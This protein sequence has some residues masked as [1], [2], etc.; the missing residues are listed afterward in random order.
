MRVSKYVKVD[1]N[2]LIEYIYDDG[3]LIGETY[4]VGVNIKN[5]NYSY[6][7]GDSSTTLNTSL[8]TLFPIDLVNNT[9][10]KYDTSIY[11]FLQ[12]KDFAGGFPI[13]HDFIKIHLPINYTFGE[14]L[15][16]YL[17]AYAFDSTLKKTY[18]LCNFYY[19]ITNLDQTTGS[20]KDLLT[21]VNPPIFFQE[22]LWGKQV[23]IMIPSL[24][25]VSHQKIN[26]VVK[27]NSINYNLT[28]GVGFDSNSPIFI[29][30]QFISNK[31]TVNS[32]TTYTLSGKNT[33]TMPQSPEF[34]K[35]GVRVEESVNGDFFEIYGVY[36]DNIGDFNDFINRSVYSGNRYYVEYK[37]TIY[38]QNIRG[39]STRIVMTDDFL[40]KVE[41][42]PIIKYSTTTAIIDVEMNLID[43][44]DLS[45]ITR[46]ASYGMLQ[47]QVSKYSLR[48]MKINLDNANKPKVYNIKSSTSQIVDNQ[49]INNLVV[50]TIKVP[51]PVLID[52]YN[53]VAKSENAVINSS[54]FFGIGKIMIVLYP[55]DNVI[56]FIIANQIKDDKIDY[57]DLTNMGEIKFNIKNQSISVEASLFSETGEIDLSKGFLVFKIV[58]SKINDIKRVYDSGINLFYITSTQQSTTSVIYSGLYKIYDS[59]DNVVTLNQSQSEQTVIPVEVNTVPDTSILTGTAIVTRKIIPVVGTVSGTFSTVVA[60]NISQNNKP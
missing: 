2:I 7:S 4:K 3:N 30:F 25:A 12:V 13:R 55:F 28:N 44:V 51:Y 34:E 53:V 8:N 54:T 39:K 41:Y 42:R 6:I 20:N 24:Y 16:F 47:D 52:K 33:V 58:S 46:R 56:K 32:L 50:E 29:E 60:D 45:Q 38:E 59:I 27:P 14:N 17:R 26:S 10:G 37:I 5:S 43:S 19:D 36:N 1:K 9:Y 22:K 18:D 11:P 31:T 35:I 49:S 40:S 48:L 57:M 21:Y 23:S 15:G